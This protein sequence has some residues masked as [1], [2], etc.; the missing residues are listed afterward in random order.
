MDI[1][2]HPKVVTEIARGREF[3]ERIS[4]ARRGIDT[5]RTTVACPEGDNQI[6]FDGAGMVVDATFC[7]EVFDRHP[8]DKL[9]DLL[10]AMCAEG[11]ERVSEAVTD[12]V[13]EALGRDEPQS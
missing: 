9:G 12:A 7:E 8:S 3:L 6:V 10:T 4:R 13:S 1:P 11:Y 2:L 5:M